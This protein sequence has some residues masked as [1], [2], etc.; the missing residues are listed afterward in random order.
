MTS[1]DD[2]LGPAGDQTR[3][4]R[5]HNGLTEYHATEDVADSTIRRLPHLF[6]AKLDN[7]GLIRGDG[8]ALHP[9]A[10]LGDGIGGFH[11]YLVVGGVS[12]ADAEVVVVELDVQVGQD[13]LV[14]DHVPD[15]PCHL[16]AI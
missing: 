10:V 4:I 13:Q 9:D 1:D 12:I 3:H 2:G 14:L 8:C 5:H 16:I 15:D 6:Q 11:R 7:S